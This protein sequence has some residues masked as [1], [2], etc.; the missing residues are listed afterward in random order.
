MSAQGFDR[1]VTPARADLA[2]AHLRGVVEAPRY[3]EARIMQVVE[4]IVDLR[5][6]PD[7]ARSIDTQALYG[8]RVFVYD[9]HEGWAWGQLERDDYVGW[10][11]MAA[12]AKAGKPATH[13]VETLRTFLYP[14]RSIKAPPLAALTHGALAH[15]D[16]IDGEFALTA[17][18]ALW[19]SH[20]APLSDHPQDFV[21]AAERYLGV[22]YLWGG[23][24]SAGTD[25][26]GLI[27]T[28]LRAVGVAA[29]RDSDMLAAT[30]GEP[31]DCDDSLA[32]LSRGDLVFWKGHCGVMQD[33]TQLLHAN[34]HHMLVVSEP[35]VEARDR[36]RD[37]SFGPITGVRRL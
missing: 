21:A 15:V 16:A 12:L 14:A 1:R 24:S 6:Q 32:G 35:L 17:Q 3:V 33:A 27:Q 23:R 10:L 25:C 31:I 28:A 37:K 2:A 34:G 22:P 26:S 19:A 7:P 18:G 36:I 8:E 11:P 20:L 9:E 5:P 30:M 29:P 4:A 13:R